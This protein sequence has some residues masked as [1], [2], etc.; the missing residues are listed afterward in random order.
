M[1]I[2]DAVGKF[3]ILYNHRDWIDREWFI[4]S[5]QKNGSQVNFDCFI[6]GGGAKPNIFYSGQEMGYSTFQKKCK[7]FTPQEYFETAHD[8]IK[9]AFGE[10]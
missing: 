3:L 2:K 1:K 10:R 8:F 4:L 7:I 6:R 9:C 5:I